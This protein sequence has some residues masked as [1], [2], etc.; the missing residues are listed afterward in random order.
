MAESESFPAAERFHGIIAFMADDSDCALDEATARL[1]KTFPDRTVTR[2]GHGIRVTATGWVLWLDYSD[3][4]HVVEESKEM[5]VWSAGHPLAA[6]IAGCKQRIE[7]SGTDIEPG[8]ECFGDLCRAAEVLAG[9]RGV[10][11]FD[12]NERSEF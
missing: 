8:G 11:V 7:F 6:H 2:T 12:I 1:R 4:P 10:I 3:R 9:F 5:A